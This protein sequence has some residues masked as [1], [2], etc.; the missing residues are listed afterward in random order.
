MSVF[1]DPYVYPGTTVLINL[2]DARDQNE[3]NK[4]ERIET[5]AGR[6]STHASTPLLH[7]QAL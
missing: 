7:L 1:V 3:L 4:V 6:R 2:F 5:W